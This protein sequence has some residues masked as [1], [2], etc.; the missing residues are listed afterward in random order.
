[1]R[2]MRDPDIRAALVTHLRETHPDPIVNRIWPEMTVGLGASR[3][4]VGLVNGMISGYEIKSAGDNL[5][6]LPSQVL[7]YSRCLDRAVIVTSSGRAK[8]IESHVPEWWGVMIAEEGDCGVYLRV[9]R[10]PRKNPEL[11]AFYVAQLLWRD[12]AYAELAA[13]GL[14]E[15]LKKA[16]RWE[17]WD[18]LAELPMSQLRDSV[19][20]RLKARPVF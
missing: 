9:Q 17:L 13:R 14:H 10:R 1:M 18:R 11:D 4:D 8:T 19:R 15:G 2:D 3:I 6:R 5:D 20:A 12:E 16:T 7:H